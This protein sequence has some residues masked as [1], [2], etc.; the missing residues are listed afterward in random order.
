MVGNIAVFGN[1]HVWTAD[2]Q[3]PEERQAWLAQ[4][5]ELIALKPTVVVP[6]HMAAGAPLDATSIRTTRDY[7]QRFDAEATKASDANALIG[8]MKTAYPDAG[9]GLALDIG[10]KVR[11][12]EMAW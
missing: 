11:K 6:G 5:D 2:T 7:L 1:L 9:L 4:L 12:G 3:R 8:A 10:A